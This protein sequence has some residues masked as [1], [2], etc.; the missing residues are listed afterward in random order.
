[1]FATSTTL[2]NSDHD[3][4]AGLGEGKDKVYVET[5][6]GRIIDTDGLA[7]RYV[8]LYSNGN[9]SDDLNHY[10]EVAVYGKA[11]S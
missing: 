6:H 10:V 1:E 9:T 5:N 8:R 3:N 11:G 2:Y 7:G 4:S